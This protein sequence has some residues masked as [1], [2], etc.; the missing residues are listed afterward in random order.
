MVI[1][2]YTPIEHRGKGYISKLLDKIP[3]PL[4]VN[5]GEDCNEIERLYVRRKV[6]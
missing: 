6:L 5:K 2:M 1:S 4:I 3:K